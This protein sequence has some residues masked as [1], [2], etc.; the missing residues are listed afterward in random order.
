[1]EWALAPLIYIVLIFLVLCIGS[2]G[3]RI[4]QTF[5]RVEESEKA[6]LFALKDLRGFIK[7][8]FKEKEK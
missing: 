7:L 3:S 2:I 8:T 1:M 4:N 5:E 6:I